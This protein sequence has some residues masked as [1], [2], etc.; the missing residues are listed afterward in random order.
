MLSKSRLPEAEASLRKAIA[1]ADKQG[2]K[3]PRLRSALSLARLVANRREPA[4][5]RALLQ[6]AYD[7]VTEGRDLADLK[8]A[9]AMLADLGNR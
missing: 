8:S 2:A 5:A 6:P 1:T 4:A 3:L 7:A 9:A